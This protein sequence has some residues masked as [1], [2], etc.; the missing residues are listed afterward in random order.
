VDEETQAEREVERLKKKLNWLLH[1]EDE[2]RY[3]KS[4]LKNSYRGLK[5]TEEYLELKEKE[6]LVAANTKN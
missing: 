5:Q 6:L 2:L 4:D 3:F 1:E